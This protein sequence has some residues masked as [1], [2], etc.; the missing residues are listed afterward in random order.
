MITITQPQAAVA[1]RAA[2][3]PDNIPTAIEVTLSFLF[4]AAA[5]IVVEYAPQAPD[6]VHNVALIR[7]LGWLW[8]AEP[9]QP[10]IGNALQTS[11]ASRLLA[12]WR[13]HRA[14]VIEGAAA[15]PPEPSPGPNLPPV[16]GEGSFVLVN[17]N[18]ELEW[19]VFPI[20][21]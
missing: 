14:G 9:D 19:I 2:T 6:D 5:A 4:K 10:G 17:N 18:G 12:Q 15:A 3:D 7:L 13:V 8:D 20:P 21:G 16:P 1:I 11:G